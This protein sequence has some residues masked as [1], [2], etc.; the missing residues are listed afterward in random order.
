VIIPATLV[1]WVALT[2]AAG[3]VC[4]FAACTAEVARPALTASPVAS[5]AAATVSAAPAAATPATT[6]AAVSTGATGAAS[7]TGASGATGAAGVIVPPSP[8]GTRYNFACAEGKTF[9]ILAFPAA[10][11]RVVLMVESK[12]LPLKQERSASGTRHSDG[13]YTL[14]QKGIDAFIEQNGAQTYRDCK[15]SRP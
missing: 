10:Q 13:N 15:A 5:P 11:E 2:A 8:D 1:R 12:T 4:T 14:I 9:S 6:P 7:S 3:V